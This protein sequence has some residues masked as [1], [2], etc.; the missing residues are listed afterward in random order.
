LAVQIPPQSAAILDAE[1]SSS[2][3][4]GWLQL[5]EG[6]PSEKFRKECARAWSRLRETGNPHAA[7]TLLD[8]LETKLREGAGAPQGIFQG[9]PLAHAALDGAR[10]IIEA[11][12]IS[13]RDLLGHLSPN[14]LAGPFW[15]I[16]LLELLA[17]RLASEPDLLQESPRG[18]LPATG[19][20]VLAPLFKSVLNEFHDFVGYRP[21]P[22]LESGRKVRIQPSERHRP[23]PLWWPGA[24]VAPIEAAPLIERA[25]HWLGATPPELLDEAGFQLATLG[26]LAMDLREFDHSQPAAQRPNHLFGEW[27]PEKIDNRGHWSR[28]VVR[29]TL[30]RLLWQHVQNPGP[31]DPPDATE[32]LEEASVLLAG[33]LLMSSGVM[34]WGPGA[35]DPTKTL[36]LVVGKIAHLR[37]RF[38]QKV[39]VALPPHHRQRLEQ[40]A[41]LLRQPFGRVRQS[42]NRA[43]AAQRATQL[44][45]RQLARLFAR[46]GLEELAK[47][48]TAQLPIPSLRLAVHFDRLMARHKLSGSKGHGSRLILGKCFSILKRGIRCGAFADPWN[49]IG[50]QGLYPIS[51]ARE[52][53]VPDHRL[54]DLLSMVASLFREVSRAYA[55][56]SAEADR[57]SHRLLRELLG[58]LTAWW[59]RYPA[60][61]DMDIDHPDAWSE[62]RSALRV[63]RAIRTWRKRGEMPADLAFWKKVLSTL[64][65]GEAVAEIFDVLLGHGDLQGAL[66]IMIYWMDA[67]DLQSTAEGRSDLQRMS[68]KWFDSWKAI[69][70]S[71]NDPSAAARIPNQTQKVENHRKLLVRAMEWIEANLPEDPPSLIREHAVPRE[72][73]KSSED[74]SKLPWEDGDGPGDEA[75]DG[76]GED[77]PWNKNDDKGG[78]DDGGLDTEFPLERA[79]Y[80]FDHHVGE[81]ESWIKLLESAVTVPGFETVLS[82]HENQLEARAGQFR[83]LLALIHETPVPKPGGEV[84]SVT[85]FERRQVM[86]TRAM[87]QV[88]ELV[89]RLEALLQEARGEGE[90]VP[91]SPEPEKKSE[92][93]PD[94]E[95]GPMFGLRLSQSF[96][97]DF[98][99]GSEKSQS[100]WALSLLD[101]ELLFQPISMGGEPGAWVRAR[102]VLWYVQRTIVRLARAGEFRQLVEFLEKAHQA[103]ISSRLGPPRVSE[104]HR[105]FEIAFVECFRTVFTAVTA[106][107]SREVRSPALFRGLMGL[108]EKFREIWLVHGRQTR[109]SSLDLVDDRMMENLRGFIRHFGRDL[110]PSRVMTLGNLKGVL[111]Q[112]VPQYLRSLE[113]NRDPLETNRLLDELEGTISLKDA[114]QRLEIVLRVV[115]ENYEAYKDYKTTTTVSDYGENLHI[116]LDFLRLRASFIRE[117]WNRQPW[118]LLHRE[119]LVSGLRQALDDWLKEVMAELKPLAAK[120]VAQLD[121]LEQRHGIRILTI[122]QEIE[123]GL[124]LPME[125]ESLLF[126][127]KDVC[128]AEDPRGDDSRPDRLNQFREELSR[129]VSRPWGV[130]RDVPEWVRVLEEKGKPNGES[131]DLGLLGPG[132]GEQGLAANVPLSLVKKRLEKL[133]GKKP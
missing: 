25:I 55:F 117:V 132:F 84:S 53:A 124:W 92:A 14:E 104:F 33:T 73:G 16:A 40:E 31:G 109:L 22:V 69:W 46:L 38:Y 85:E 68:R 108:M 129:W 59:A 30:I 110:F 62:Q 9:P 6:R 19:L 116:L 74:S 64:E 114:S 17:R 113:R 103:E 127:L 96:H 90:S 80:G 95:T 34:G 7:K 71:L 123:E 2:A 94:W 111:D 87:E 97:R 15:L 79:L 27:D 13:R 20:E 76:D 24:G 122:R 99:K 35:T 51:P 49:L 115:V 81:F 72:P 131:A 21:L 57:E 39:I 106:A 41:R 4:L 119:L 3:L 101:Q 43:M 28:L 77:E 8:W 83:E 23:A 65:T 61:S 66:G 58:E 89:F 78:L 29:S 86:K 52:D 126:R 107:K 56:A 70:E 100:Q 63:A 5:S 48:R 125:T 10:V 112:G 98:L 75:E 47:E 130:G 1:I 121:S 32:R 26:E 11:T 120:Y 60:K 18:L 44:Q 118:Y 91:A 102:T 88:G 93:P 105:Y 45:D 37:D 12:R 128:Q 67:F 133:T 42:L 36:G 50:F 82:N 54:E